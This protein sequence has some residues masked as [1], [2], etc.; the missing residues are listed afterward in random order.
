[1]ELNLYLTPKQGEMLT[2]APVDLI[3]EWAATGRIRS[4]TKRLY[5][6]GHL[7]VRTADVIG[8]AAADGYCSLAE[9]IEPI[10]E[11]ASDC[12]CSRPRKKPGATEVR[13]RSSVS[14]PDIAFAEDPEGRR[15]SFAESH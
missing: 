14:A 15:Q 6:T 12:C 4:A 9:I 3:T 1:M 13:R 7:V 11:E 8:A 5:S 10:L 2:G